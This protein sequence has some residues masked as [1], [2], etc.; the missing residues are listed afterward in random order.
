MGVW[1]ERWPNLWSKNKMWLDLNQTK[2]QPL[3]IWS[4]PDLDTIV[5]MA[6]F[7]LKESFQYEY[8]TGKKNWEMYGLCNKNACKHR[9]C[10]KRN[11]NTLTAIDTYSKILTHFLAD[12]GN[13][14]K[15]KK[16]HKRFPSLNELRWWEDDHEPREFSYDD[17]TVVGNIHPTP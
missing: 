3:E 12:T 8:C 15:I 4:V 1:D 11:A 13:L 5:E 7:W 9:E 2:Q 6:A 17:D 16:R 10:I 14:D